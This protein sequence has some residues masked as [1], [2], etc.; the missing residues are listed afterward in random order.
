MGAEKVVNCEHIQA[1]SRH[2]PQRHW[3][4]QED[5]RDDWARVFSSPMSCRV[6][7]VVARFFFVCRSSPVVCCR[8][9]FVVPCSV[10]VCCCMWLCCVGRR[11]KGGMHRTHLHVYVQIVTV[12]YLHQA[13]MFYTC[14]RGARTHGSMADIWTQSVQV[15]ELANVCFR[16]MF[17]CSGPRVSAEQRS[18]C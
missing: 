12:L 1:L 16:A 2:E 5:P 4:S 14:G 9:S 7:R 15:F 10:V 3:K 11:E 6:S 13:H 18:S 8:L 17:M